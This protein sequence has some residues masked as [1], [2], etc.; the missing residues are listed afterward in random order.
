[1]TVNRG[2][3]RLRKTRSKT[4]AALAAVMRL[5]PGSIRELAREAGLSEG[6]LRQARDGIIDLAPAKVRKVALALRRWSR[7]TAKLADRLEAAL[8]AEAERRQR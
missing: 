1:L 6:A 4:S 2:M 5:A 8:E 7:T 3:R